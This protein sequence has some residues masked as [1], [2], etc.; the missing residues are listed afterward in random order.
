MTNLT[1]LSISACLFLMLL[2]S[3]L[4]QS[5]DDRGALESAGITPRL[6]AFGDAVPGDKAI[7]LLGVVT[8]WQCVAKGG[9]AES[10]AFVD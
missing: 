5:T 7:G 10:S 6:T 3:S 9:G 1:G 2:P 4:V 8:Q